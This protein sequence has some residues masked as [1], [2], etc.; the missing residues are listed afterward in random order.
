MGLA[1]ARPNY[2]RNIFCHPA[3]AVSNPSFYYD[4]WH[5]HVTAYLWIIHCRNQILCTRYIPSRKIREIRLFRIWEY[6]RSH[7]NFTYTAH[8]VTPGYGCGCSQAQRSG[9]LMMSD[10]FRAKCLLT[11]AFKFR[12]PACR[13]TKIHLVIRHRYYSVPVNL[14]LVAICLVLLFVLPLMEPAPK[15][16]H[17]LFQLC[18]WHWKCAEK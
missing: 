17:L 9:G 7:C 3:H 10:E 16:V 4:L 5:V 15:L 6:L 1:Q 12:N 14:F 8:A 2:G 18:S 13:M 11:D